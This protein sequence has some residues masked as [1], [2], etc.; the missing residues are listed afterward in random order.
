MRIEV[1]SIILEAESDKDIQDAL[2]AAYDGR[3]DLFC[4]CCLSRPRLYLARLDDTYVSKRWPHTGHEHDPSCLIS[5][6]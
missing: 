5:S 1:D 2:K 3:K 6:V 4:L